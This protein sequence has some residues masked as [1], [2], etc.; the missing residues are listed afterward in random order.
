MSSYASK[1]KKKSPQKP[2][3]KFIKLS[4][5]FKTDI[6]RSEVYAKAKN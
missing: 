6:R 4:P 3:I 1:K 2:T 5:P